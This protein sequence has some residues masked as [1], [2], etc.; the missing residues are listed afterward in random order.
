[1]DITW[2]NKNPKDE[3]DW[4]HNARFLA[5]ILKDQNTGDFIYVAFNTSHME[6][7]VQIPD[8][9]ER[10]WLYVVNTSRMPPHDHDPQFTPI[11]QDILV[12]QPYSSL[13]LKAAAM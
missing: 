10:V 3:P 6:T 5:F 1:M 13:V 8:S 7:E 9:F 11:P 12:M 4:S 2:L